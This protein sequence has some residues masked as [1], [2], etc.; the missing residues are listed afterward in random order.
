V[1]KNDDDEVID[2]SYDS[3]FEADFFGGKNPEK[4]AEMDKN[5]N[6]V[7]SDS[8]SDDDQI[9]S[10]KKKEKFDQNDFKDDLVT[11]VNLDLKRF[12]K[13]KIAEGIDFVK[14]DKYGF[15]I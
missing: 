4:N 14:Y 3:E 2:N 11:D 12:E 1:K 6:I 5:F 15:E 10:K 8:D 7:H 13:M 9:D